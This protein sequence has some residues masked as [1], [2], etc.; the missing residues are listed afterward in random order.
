MSVLQAKETGR[1]ESF[2]LAGL[3]PVPPE[4][5]ILLKQNSIYFSKVI[6]DSLSFGYEGWSDLCL[7]FVKG[8]G[9]Q[10]HL[11]RP[12]VS[13]FTELDGVP[14]GMVIWLSWSHVTQ[15][16]PAASLD[17]TRLCLRGK[18]LLS[19]CCSGQWKSL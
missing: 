5:L 12:S 16:V 4:I 11:I 3:W 9:T 14:A 1:D 19:G 2:A 7:G 18:L 10:H 13:D 17:L 8:R 6:F 15:P